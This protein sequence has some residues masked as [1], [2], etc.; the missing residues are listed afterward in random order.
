MA[1]SVRSP[2][3]PDG[4]TAIRQLLQLGSEKIERLAHLL[5]NI[6]PT[7][8]QADVRARMLCQADG[9]ITSPGELENI[10]TNALLPLKSIRDNFGISAA[11]FYDVVSDWLKKL[12]SK[13]WTQEDLEKW[14]SL[15]QEIIEL[16]DLP[17][18]SVESRAWGLFEDRANWV[19]DLTI[20]ADMRPIVD[21]TAETLQAMLIVNTLRI[22][23]RMGERSKIAYFSLDPVD[24]DEL[25]H[26]IK[27]VKK[28]NLR[29][30]QQMNRNN[31]PA[32]M[33]EHREESSKNDGETTP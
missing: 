29:L 25:E 12:V 6:G 30:R 21:E 7:F 3:P 8:A 16:F 22:R 28:V 19:Q 4:A 17:V 18:F 20:H 24:L 10:L 26:Q 27:L 33:L 13:T 31:I 9:G 2:I 23:Y 15:K 5:Q 1:E 11:A 32:L 14:E